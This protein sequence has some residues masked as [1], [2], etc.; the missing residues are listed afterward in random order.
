ME[1]LT[2]REIRMALQ[3]IGAEIEATPLTA[4]GAVHLKHE[5]KQRTGSFKIRGALNKVFGLEG[6]DLDREIICA[7]AGNHGQ[8]VALAASLRGMRCTVVVPAQA[9]TVKL[10]AIRAHGAEL[11]PVEGGYGEAEQ[12]GL[13]LAEARSAIWISPYNDRAV[14]AGQSTLGWELA[15]QMDE[16][17]LPAAAKVY[18]PVSGGGLACGVGLALKLK[19]PQVHVVGVQTAAAPYMHAFFTGGSFDPA[20]EKST[21]ADG[22][23]GPVEAGSIT[24]ECL[25]QAVDAMETVSEGEIEDAMCWLLER[26][27]EVEPSA[28]VPLAA[29]RAAEPGRHVVILS[30]GNIDAAL[31]EQIVKRCP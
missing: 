18:V 12:H 30:G 2:E 16:M 3:R 27:I 23:A 24:F 15:D 21:I 19:R 14:I 26:G 6:Q 13:A 9:P 1:P 25:G 31:L 4:S 22:L 10:D 20:R 29:A 8:G 5:H 17:A 11:V 7:S 28:A